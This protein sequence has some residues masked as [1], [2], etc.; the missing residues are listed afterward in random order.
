MRSILNLISQR[1]ANQIEVIVRSDN[2]MIMIIANEARMFL[3][4]YIILKI[5]VTKIIRI[6]QFFIVFKK[7]SYFMILKRSWFKNVAI[8]DYYESDE[9]WIKNLS[10]NYNKLNVYESRFNSAKKICMKEC[11]LIEILSRNRLS[12]DDEILINLDYEQN[13]LINA[14]LKELKI[15]TKIEKKWNEMKMKEFEEES[16]KDQTL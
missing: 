5:I 6:V 4:E 16:R 11:V 8:I 14:M 1:I 7:I 3:S 2:F 12:V 15:K 9:Y 13:K 10:K